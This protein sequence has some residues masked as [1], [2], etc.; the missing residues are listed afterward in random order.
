[1]RA[2]MTV[3]RYFCP[4]GAHGPWPHSAMEFR[5]AKFAYPDRLHR[6]I[7][8]SLNHV[9]SASSPRAV[10]MMTGTCEVRRM[11]LTQSL[12][13]SWMIGVLDQYAR[14]AVNIYVHGGNARLGEYLREIEDVSFLQSTL[15]DPENRDILGRGVPQGAEQVLAKARATGETQFHIGLLWTGASVVSGPDGRYIL[16][17]KVLIPYGGVLQGALATRGSWTA[18]SSSAL[19]DS[20][21]ADSK[22]SRYSPWTLPPAENLGHPRSS[23]DRRQPLVVGSV[24]ISCKESCQA[25]RDSGLESPNQA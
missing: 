4:F 15:L 14:S 23:C 22:S 13:P 3:R 8:S 18:T 2:R 17:A 7:P 20:F 9:R 19:E 11:R 12:G 24:A 1:M 6:V 25:R 21:L 5:T 10:S 16:V